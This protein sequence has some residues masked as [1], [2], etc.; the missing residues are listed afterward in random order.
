MNKTHGSR[1]QD[2]EMFVKMAILKEDIKKAIG[3]CE[4]YGIDN[5]RFGQ[6]VQEVN[7]IK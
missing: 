3:I 1:K 6:L 7:K 4:H 5:K 2:I